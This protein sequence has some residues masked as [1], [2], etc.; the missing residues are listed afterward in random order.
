MDYC[1]NCTEAQ[2]KKITKTF[3]RNMMTRTIV[4]N[5]YGFARSA[6]DKFWLTREECGLLEEFL[7]RHKAFFGIFPDK[8]PDAAQCI[9]EM[10]EEAK[11]FSD[12]FRVT[13]RWVDAYKRI[14]PNWEKEPDKEHYFF[15]SM[16]FVMDAIEEYSRW[17]EIV[18]RDW[19]AK[20][21]DGRGGETP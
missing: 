2:R 17:L 16:S 11:R 10:R 7:T 3:T 1:T 18:A 8:E 14:Y 13:K 12:K 21:N 9:K 15:Y 5:L 4:S 20:I 19:E 6:G